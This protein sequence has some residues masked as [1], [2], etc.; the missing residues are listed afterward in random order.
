MSGKGYQINIIDTPGHIDFTAEVQRSLRV[1]DGGV[2]VFDAV[3]GVEPQSETVWRQADRYGVPRVAFVN[4][5]DRVGADFDRT[6]GMIRERLG[7]HPVAIQLPIGSEREFQGAVD[8]IT[9]Q[10]WVYTSELGAN[11]EEIDIPEDL[12]EEAKA[13]REYMVEV[14]AETNDDLTLKYLEGEVI[15][16][17]ELI[18]SLREATI[19]GDLVAVLCG[20]SLKNKGVQPLLDAVVNYLPSPLERPPISGLD[21][22]TGETVTRYT[23]FDEP[24]TALV[25]KI[26][27]DPYVGR[28]AYVRVYSGILKSGE[29][30]LNVTRGRKERIGRLMRIY[31]EKREEI[32]EIGAGDIAAII[33]LKQSFTGETLTEPDKSILLEAITFPEPVISVAI[34]PRTKADQDKLA[35]ALGR[36]SDEDPTFQVRVDDTTGQTLISGMGEL[37]LEVLID[38]M[39]REFKVSASVGQPQV[40]YRE[41]IT[42]VADVEG[43][44]VRQSG[45]RGQFGHVRVRFEPLEPGSG[46]VFENAIVGGAVPREFIRSVELGIQDALEGGSVGGYPIVDIKAVLYDGSY[47][48]VDSSEMAFRIA[49][50]FAVREGIPRAKPIL[51]EPVMRVEVVAPEEYLGD[52]IGDL[53]SRRGQIEGME[54]HSK[55]MQAIRALA[56]LAEMFGYA[57]RLR[58]VTQGRGTFTQ[59]F[60]RYEPVP[61][62][63]ARTFLKGIQ[64]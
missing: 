62:S 28:L 22:K 26:I 53:S 14:I 20:S 12:V 42:Q 21:S 54:V 27:T 3:A 10:A 33:G 59:E 1:L 56:P 31:A 51:L 39:I 63:V 17:E 32:K 13:A 9:M 50:S 4:K 24:T 30:M 15:S 44:F 37:H 7:A 52:I 38:R 11:P 41:T 2:V 19:K 55:G 25:F 43:R 64:A 57:T 46:Y 29:T 58:S 16:Q 40:A 6:I 36:L 48:E 8:L 34:E 49:G 18:A 23:D 47:H 61:E 60:E 35:E 5:M 45:G